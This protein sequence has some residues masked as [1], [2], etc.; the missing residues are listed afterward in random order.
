MTTGNDIKLPYK[1]KVEDYDED[2]RWILNFHQLIGVV[3]VSWVAK[4]NA[5]VK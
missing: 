2:E 5:G 3:D 1:E 4:A